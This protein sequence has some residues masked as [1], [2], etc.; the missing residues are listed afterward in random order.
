[1]FSIAFSRMPWLAA[2]F[3]TLG[4]A[5]LALGAWLKVDLYGQYLIT[6]AITMAVIKPKDDE[7]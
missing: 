4:V 7:K 5:A 1:M 3:A 2:Y 6:S